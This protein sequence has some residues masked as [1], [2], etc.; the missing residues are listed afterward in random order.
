MPFGGLI[1]SKFV[2]IS[3]GRSI[4]LDYFLE[5]DMDKLKEIKKYLI[6]RGEDENYIAFFQED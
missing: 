4:L 6:D 1:N 5:D 3:K 2:I